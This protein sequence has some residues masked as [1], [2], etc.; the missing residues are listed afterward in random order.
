MKI[1]IV[2]II[3]LSRKESRKEFEEIWRK[4][5]NGELESQAVISDNEEAQSFWKL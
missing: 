4:L 2:A 5:F 3:I 1:K